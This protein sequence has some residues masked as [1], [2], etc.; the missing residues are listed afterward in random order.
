[1]VVVPSLECVSV[2]V[3]ITNDLA[4]LVDVVEPHHNGPEDED[5]EKGVAQVLLKAEHQ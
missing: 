1:M 3:E 2:L 4:D 5:L